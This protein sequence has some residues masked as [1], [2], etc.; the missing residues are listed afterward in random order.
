M[1]PA[2]RPGRLQHGQLAL[3]VDERRAGNVVLEI[4]PAPELRFPQLPPAVDELSAP[5]RLP[6][7]PGEARFAGRLTPLAAGSPSRALAVRL[8]VLSRARSV[9]SLPA[10]LEEREEA[11]LGFGASLSRAAVGD[12]EKLAFLSRQTTRR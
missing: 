9:G 10:A 2:D 7:W 5:R 4:Q 3:D 12:D 6:L 11:R 8:C 1:P